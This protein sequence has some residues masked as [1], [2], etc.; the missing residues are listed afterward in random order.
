M[1]DEQETT[2]AKDNSDDAKYFTITPRL[3]WALA[4]NVY[5]Y[6]LWGVVKDIAGDKGECFLSREDMAALAMMSTGQVSDSRTYLMSVG[7]LQGRLTRDPGYPQPVWHLQTPNLWRRNIEW[8]EQCPTIRERVIWKRDQKARAIPKEPSWGDG[9]ASWS[10]GGMSSGDAKNNHKKNQKEDAA[11]AAATPS[12]PPRTPEEARQR[13]AAAMGLGEAQTDSLT[14]ALEMLT[15]RKIDPRNKT[16]GG[17]IADLREWGAVPA[18]C[19]H[20]SHYAQ[21]VLN[22]PRKPG[23]AGWRGTHWKPTL[24]EVWELWETAMQWQP[25]QPEAVDE[26]T[27]AR[28]LETAGYRN[29]T[30]NRR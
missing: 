17:Y 28:Q 21:V 13:V 18:K 5:D 20:F 6:A 9:K 14:H 25:N 4:R 2:A 1:S 23:E 16:A 26:K 22:V 8:V 27:R 29:F 19:A 3:V 30:T 24:K 7:L 11:G 12:S 15:G 10:D